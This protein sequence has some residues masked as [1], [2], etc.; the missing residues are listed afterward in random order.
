MPGLFGAA[1][2]YALIDFLKSAYL[3]KAFGAFLI[4]L[5]F[6]EI[7]PFVKRLIAKIKLKKQRA[8]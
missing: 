2:G 6:R 1:A 7:L 3:K 5:A 8:R 4:I